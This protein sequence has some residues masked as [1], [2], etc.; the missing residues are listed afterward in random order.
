MIEIYKTSPNDYYIYVP[1]ITFP[2]F[3]DNHILPCPV[4]IRLKLHGSDRFADVEFLRTEAGFLNKQ[5]IFP[6]FNRGAV[7]TPNAVRAFILRGFKYF[8]SLKMKG[9]EI[10]GVFATEID[11]T[12]S[13]KRIVTS[14]N[15]L[16]GPKQPSGWNWIELNVGFCGPRANFGQAAPLEDG[17]GDVYCNF[18][19]AA[20]LADGGGDV[21]CKTKIYFS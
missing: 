5:N 13:G 2:S 14:L 21:Y 15:E 19:H 12:H 1:N 20:P 9:L 4:G 18:G 8:P 6:Y 10:G 16:W 17:G 3:V 11:A 7:V